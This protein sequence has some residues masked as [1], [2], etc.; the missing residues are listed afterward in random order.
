MSFGGKIPQCN[1]GLLANGNDLDDDRATH[2]GKE[3]LDSPDALDNL[4]SAVR[5]VRL[6]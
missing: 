2:L 1:S 3:P 5:Q 6:G 4:R